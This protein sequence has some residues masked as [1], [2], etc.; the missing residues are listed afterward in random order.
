M[1]MVKKSHIFDKI[2]VPIE[3]VNPFYA[4]YPLWVALS[5]EGKIFENFTRAATS[6]ICESVCLKKSTKTSQE[7]GGKNK[8]T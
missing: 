1:V 7:G 8:F 5:V 3:A 6:H 4:Y 2:Y